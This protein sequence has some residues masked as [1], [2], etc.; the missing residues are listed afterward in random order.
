M[1]GLAMSQVNRQCTVTVLCYMFQL[2]ITVISQESTF[3]WEEL[4]NFKT[5]LV[6]PLVTLELH[7]L[8]SLP[9]LQTECLAVMYLSMG[10]GTTQMGPKLDSGLSHLV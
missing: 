7:H 10:T 9:A 1:I 3:L 5:T 4:L 6:Y 8:I 2:E